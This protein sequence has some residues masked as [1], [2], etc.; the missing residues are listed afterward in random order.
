[1]KKKNTILVLGVYN[2]LYGK[3]QKG[4]IM[5]YILYALII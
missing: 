3:S 2:I 1:M 4:Y 5:F